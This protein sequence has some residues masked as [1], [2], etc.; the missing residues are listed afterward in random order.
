M[1][2]SGDIRVKTDKKYKQLY[3]DLRNIAF[4]DMH[5]LF[6]LCVCLGYREDQ[7]K[8]LASNG[9]ERFWSRTISPEEW[10][11]YYA[12][13]L[14]K[15]DMDLS[16]IKDDKAVIL[17]MEKYANGGMEILLNKFLNDYCLNDLKL[18][19]TFSKELPKA[20]LHFIREEL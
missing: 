18:D 10:A 14:D 2:M 4:G 1:N 11:C 15:N 12:I 6:F 13:I 3:N 19:P 9:E 7:S 5:E 20:I 17:E 8:S 16:K